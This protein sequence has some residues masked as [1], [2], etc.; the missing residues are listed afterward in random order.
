MV[1]IGQAG[2][3]NRGVRGRMMAFSETDGKRLWSFDLVPLTGP[4]ADFWPPNTPE[5]PRT[6]GA[7][8]TS[9]TLDPTQLVAGVTTTAGD[10]VL[11]GDLNGDVLAFNAADGKQLWKHSTGAPIGGGV[12]TSLAGGKQYVA[13]APGIASAGW[14]TSGSN[15]KV[16]IYALP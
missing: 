1:F 11:T 13:V 3:D 12:I 8:W 9:Y 2:G 10:L 4:G 6:G 5:N 15:A 7:T 14:Q 16:A